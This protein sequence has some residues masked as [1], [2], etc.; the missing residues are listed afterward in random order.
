MKL[1]G[2]VSNFYILVPVS[3]LY[4]PTVGLLTQYIKIG[5]LM[6]GI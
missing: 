1:R 3:D 5:R 2:L 6:V 4:I